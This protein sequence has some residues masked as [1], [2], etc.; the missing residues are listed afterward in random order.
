MR[1]R[2][3]S[4]RG[5]AI[6]VVMMVVALMSVA[7]IAL[8]DFVNLDLVLVGVSRVRAEAT[9]AAEGA[10]LEVLEDAEARNF[11]PDLTS[12]TLSAGYTPP[13]ETPL[14]NTA[15]GRSYTSEVKLLRFVPVRETS[16]TWSRALVYE[17]TTVSQSR[18]R[19]ATSEVRVVAYKTIAVP[20]GVT[21]PRRHAR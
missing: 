5:F 18:Q 9:L 2:R 6:L 12:T 20:V 7:G 4:A 19:N 3:S 13:A 8:L 1:R 10:S 15:A 14:I 16:A 21:Y 11:L 17:V